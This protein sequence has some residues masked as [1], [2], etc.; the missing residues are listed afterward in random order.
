MLETLLH[1]IEWLVSGAAQALVWGIIL[2][3]AMS[4]YWVIGCL[5]EKDEDD[6]A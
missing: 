3:F 2:I 6:H 4:I 1:F 5:V